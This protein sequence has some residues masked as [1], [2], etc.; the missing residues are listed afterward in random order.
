M[1]NQIKICKICKKTNL[2][3]SNPK[4]QIKISK[5]GYYLSYCSKCDRDRNFNKKNTFCNIC[6]KI[7]TVLFYNNHNMHYCDICEPTKIMTNK[8]KSKYYYQLK[9]NKKIQN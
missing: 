2:L 4:D 3:I 6:N 1:E 9:K 5:S 8:Q 7:K